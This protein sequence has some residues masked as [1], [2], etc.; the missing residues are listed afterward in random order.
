MHIIGHSKLIA[1]VCM[2][3]LCA[4]E[5]D[6]FVSG[7]PQIQC[8]FNLSTVEVELML[9]TNLIA[10]AIAAFIVGNFSDKYGSR[11]C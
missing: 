10:G 3:I 2:E 9:V 1:A 6:I 8:L 11:H 5:L 4:A 7:L